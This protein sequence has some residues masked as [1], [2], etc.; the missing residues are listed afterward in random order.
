MNAVQAETKPGIGLH[1]QLLGGFAVT[2]GDWTIP[3]IQWKSRRAS[4]LIKLLALAPTHRLHRDQIIEALWS[5]AALSTA[6][7]NF[8]QTL[9]ITRHI[10]EPDAPGCLRLEEGFLT[11]RGGRLPTGEERALVVDVEH[12]ETAGLRSV[13]CQDP[14][15]IEGILL[16]YRGELLPEDLYEEFTL[17]RRA[18]V[19]KI[20]ANLLL[21]LAALYEMRKEYS[22]G[23]QTLQRLLSA[24]RSHEEAHTG[25]MRFYALNGQRQQALRQFQ[26]LREAMRE[27][28]DT[29]PGPEAAGLH[30]A[31]LS[32]QFPH[33]SPLAFDTLPAETVPSIGEEAVRSENIPNNLPAPLT[34][35]IGRTAEM[36][37]VRT[38]LEKHRLITLTG[39]G[40]VG[41]TQLALQVALGSINLTPRHPYPAGIWFIDLAPLA[42]PQLVLTTVASVLGMA[43]E[44][45]RTL[46]DLLVARLKDRQA[47]LLF[48]NCEHLIDACASL[49][50]ILLLGAPR[51]KI[52]ATSREPLGAP[53]EAVF[54]VPTLSFPQ[55]G[56]TITPQSMGAPPEVE[57]LLQYDAVRLFCDRA[58][59]ALPDF[60]L[61]PDNAAAVGNICRRLDGVPLAI[62]LAAAQVASLEVAEITVRLD[63]VFRLLSVGGRGVSERQ[64]TLR[65]TIDWSYQLL[66]PAERAL[67][68]RLSV[69]AGGWTLAD[70]QAVCSG[71]MEQGA[72]SW[73]SPSE[74]LP[75]LTQLV[76]KSMVIR[77]E[78]SVALFKQPARYRLLETLRQYAREK[79]AGDSLTRTVE[80]EYWQDRHLQFFSRLSVE[81]EEKLGTAERIE[82]LFQQDAELDNMRSAMSW[83]M[84][85]GWG[86]RAESGLWLAS[87]LFMKWTYGGLISEGQAWMEK[88]LALLPKNAPHLGSLHVKA[89][90]VLGQ[91]YCIQYQISL[92]LSMMEESIVR[93]LDCGDPLD[94]AIS[95]YGLAYW[96]DYV[97]NDHY[98][99]RRLYE[100]IVPVY[101]QQ[102]HQPAAK[103][104]LAVA[105]DELGVL[106]LAESDYRR[107]IA[108]EQ[109]SVDL[110]LACG[111]RWTMVYPLRTLAAAYALQGE[112]ATSRSYANKTLPIF[113]EL[114]NL[115]YLLHN[116]DN[117][118]TRGGVAYYL[119]DYPL[120]ETVFQRS[121]A[122]GLE[123][124]S[125][126]LVDRSLRMLTIANRRQGRIAR[127]GEYAL[128]ALDLQE[129]N[130][131]RYSQQ[132]VITYIAGLAVDVGQS[133]RATVLLGA[134]EALFASL[135]KPM[136]DG[137][138]KLEF[139]RDVETLHGQLSEVVFQA[140]WA[141]GGALSLEQAI[142]EARTT[143]SEMV[144]TQ[145][146]TRFVD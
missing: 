75:L 106:A 4:R 73:T 44:P 23:I 14:E 101:R 22:H 85:D 98:K 132:L 127:A 65:A 77:V 27:E 39:A 92:G 131:D 118:G 49:A 28:F 87:S 109:E 59:A 66:S 58:Q 93:A 8:H 120:M 6:A 124:G 60:V 34:S 11:L 54:R 102:F 119:G 116:P 53:G 24:D 146:F 100:E 95:K 99:A 15:I 96:L 42:D 30:T 20:Y 142:Q 103:W 52:L 135:R 125:S 138:D 38:I 84:A 3:A 74:V 63:N 114:K 69:F 123:F 7:N 29:E 122:Q 51:L 88:G 90:R 17:E 97:G 10:L 50:S 5:E 32:G 33:P 70:A 112:T 81:I 130:K 94:V 128:Q 143:A 18:S 67:F 43:E 64:R 136:M 57:E 86:S 35:F 133:R 13:D 110:F 68:N 19:R 2:I 145:A 45:G 41:K 76:S 89:L 78:G 91:I 25:M 61:G 31:I 80:T 12:F 137:W 1:I 47:L 83:A 71:A 117:G 107:T 105:L 9:H 126:F 79:L 55:F 144:Q 82:R 139:A 140:A 62:E 141:E 104:M 26:D 56:R 129:V 16:S 108:L 72:S 134:S 46:A 111:D 121:L 48:D 115:P 37:R 113:D 21:K 36:A 40:G